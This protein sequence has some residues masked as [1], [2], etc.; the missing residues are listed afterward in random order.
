MFE[1]ADALESIAHGV[2]KDPDQLDI[3][4]PAS[5]SINSLAQPNLALK[6]KVPIPN[7]LP[8][9]C[10]ILVLRLDRVSVQ[11]PKHTLSSW[12]LCNA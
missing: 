8:G 1:A 10:P 2:L 7:M 11:F 9:P 6:L 12:S 5:Q 3:D 4:W